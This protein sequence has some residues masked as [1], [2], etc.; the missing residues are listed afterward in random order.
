[1][2]T[3][4]VKEAQNCPAE[5][6]QYFIPPFG[7]VNECTEPHQ[8][9][10]FKVLVVWPLFCTSLYLVAS[11]PWLNTWRQPW[12]L[13]LTHWPQQSFIKTIG[14]HNPILQ[15]NVLKTIPANNLRPQWPCPI[16]VIS[17]LSSFI[18]T[19]SPLSNFDLSTIWGHVHTF[20]SWLSLLQLIDH[21]VWHGTFCH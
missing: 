1:M 16:L 9:T 13:S 20:P 14:I 15:P 11:T 5:I 17:V 19:L 18:F 3:K 6:I 21:L 7:F 2:L 4:G 10:G 12:S 8:H